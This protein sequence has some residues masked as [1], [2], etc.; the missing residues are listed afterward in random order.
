MPDFVIIAAL[1]REVHPLVRHWRVVDGLGGPY[2][3]FEHGAVLV[4]CSGI[5]RRAARRMAETVVSLFKPKVLLSIGLA[6]ALGPELRVGAIIIPAEIVD[7]STGERI[8]VGP[9][10]KYTLVSASGVASAEAKRLLARQY[11]A[12]AVD[13]EAAA[14]AQVARSAGIRFAAVKAISDEYDF[15]LPDMEPFIQ[16]NGRFQTMRFVSHVAAHPD[17]WGVARRLARNTSRAS[18]ELCRVLQNLIEKGTLDRIA[19]P[20][21]NDAYNILG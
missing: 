18:L 13:M 9:E 10:G 15:P 19:S 16:E 6:G 14:V 12:A 5:G 20:T 21:S 3:S 1:E 11:D 7:S 4:A 8:S 2:R 17:L